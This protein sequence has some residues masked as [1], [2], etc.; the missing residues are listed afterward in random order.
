MPTR[1]GG[2]E[3]QLG[4]PLPSGI[5]IFGGMLREKRKTRSFVESREK[6]LTSTRLKKRI[7]RETAK[8][9]KCHSRFFKMKSVS[10]FFI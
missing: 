8:C 4:E 10:F 7:I 3:A 6:C 5:G 9:L 1:T 2:P